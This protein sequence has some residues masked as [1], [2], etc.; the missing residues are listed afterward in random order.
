MEVLET[1]HQ[2]NTWEHEKT[3]KTK[4][5]KVFVTVSHRGE[6]AFHEGWLSRKEA[7]KAARV[8]AKKNGEGEAEK[9]PNARPQMTQTMENYLELHRHAV[10]RLALLGDPATAFRLM[11]AH[12]IAPTGNWN[13]KSDPQRARSNEIGASITKSAGQAKFE[14]EREAIEALLGKSM[15]GDTVTIFAHLLTLTDAQVMRVAA[16]AMADTLAVG[17]VCVEAAGVYLKANAGEVWQPDDLFFELIRDRVTVN[18]VLAD[19]AGKSVAKA[20]A[21]EKAK[22]QKQVIRDCLAGEN[23]RAK[24]ENWLPGWMQFPF[25]PYG[26]GASHIAAATKTVAKALSA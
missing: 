19:V 4:G 6:V 21:D 11:V 14:A 25:K 3:P 7:Q 23:G 10:V 16:F 17:D 26:K 18:A 1:G 9:S 20:N 2:F 24:I 13:V 15:E 22:T 5:G 12:A 8:D